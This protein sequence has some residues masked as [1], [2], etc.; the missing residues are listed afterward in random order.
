MVALCSLLALLIGY[1]ALLVLG[2]AF[3]GNG[4]VLGG[5]V[6]FAFGLIL[7]ILSPTVFAL[8]VWKWFLPYSE[9]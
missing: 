6:L 1:Y 2:A 8:G 7:L 3:S 4:S 5:A 9:K